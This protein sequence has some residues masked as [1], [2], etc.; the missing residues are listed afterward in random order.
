MAVTNSREGLHGRIFTDQ[1]LASKNGMKFS[2]NIT[3]RN[4]VV[5]P[6]LHRPEM[7]ALAL[8]RIRS[9]PE[10]GSLD[11]R[12][13]VDHSTEAVLDDFEYVRDEY[14]PEA[15]IYHA[16][17]H[18]Y[19]PSGCWNILNALK[20]GYESGAEYIFL[21]EEDIMTYPDYFT[22]NFAQSGDHFATCGRFIRAHFSDYYTN[23]GACFRSEKLKLVIPHI[24]DDYFAFRRDYLNRVFPPVMDDASDLDDGLIRRVIRSVNGHVLYPGTPKVAHQGFHYYNKLVQYKIEGSISERI[25]SARNLLAR[26][27][28]ADRY[29]HDF[30]PLHLVQ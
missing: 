7:A 27:Q 17:E 24:C 8:E 3:P 14:F 30:E 11:V 25:E 28:S 4:I 13:F 18:I 9:T 21:I 15:T 2:M 1:M 29:S 6:A 5:M 20:A 22:W 26:V 23:P 10:A 12:I 16:G 19:A